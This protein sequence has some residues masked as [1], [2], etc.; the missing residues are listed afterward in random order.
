MSRYYKPNNSTILYSNT[1]LNCI[2]S[3]S[4]TVTKTGNGSGYTSSPT[5]VIK[6][7]PGD[8]GSGAVATIPAPSSG[9]LSGTLAMVSN[10]RGYNTLPT[11]ELVGGGNPGVITG[12]TIS[13]QGSGYTSIPT[14]TITGGGGTGATA[15]AN[16]EG[17]K[18]I[19]GYLVLSD[20]R[21]DQRR[22]GPAGRIAA[23]PPACR[24]GHWHCALCTPRLDSLY[25]T[26]TI[27]TP[28]RAA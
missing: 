3:N 7:A 17:G 13:N 12:A 6:P 24:T 2:K 14:V 20:I 21:T 23:P 15:T 1:S 28:L 11:V 5:V 22:P 16:I 10:G 25:S 9:V 19:S 27:L 4:I 18:V 26:G 8:M